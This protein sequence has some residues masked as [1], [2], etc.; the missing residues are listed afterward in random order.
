MS[1]PFGLPAVFFVWVQ[2]C[3]VCHGDGAVGNHVTPDLRQASAETHQNWLAIVL[4]GMHWQQGMV[5]FA[6]VLTPAQATQIQA[7]AIERSQLAKQAAE[8]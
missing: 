3:I 5:G 6:E 8:P 2:F 7:Y 1:L 4:G